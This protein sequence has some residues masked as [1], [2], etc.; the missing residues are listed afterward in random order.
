MGARLQALINQVLRA[1]GDGCDAAVPSGRVSRAD[2]NFPFP[3]ACISAV[4]GVGSISRPRHQRKRNTNEV[5][6]R[7]FSEAGPLRSTLVWFVC[8]LANM[9][10]GEITPEEGVLNSRGNK[11]PASHLEATSN[12]AGSCS[13]VSDITF[14]CSFFLFLVLPIS[15]NESVK[16]KWPSPKKIDDQGCFNE[17]C[18]RR[19][20]P[21]RRPATHAEREVDA[22]LCRRLIQPGRPLQ[23]PT[24]G[25]I[26]QGFWGMSWDGL[27][28][29]CPA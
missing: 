16:K 15:R 4:Q 8:F 29:T 22:R 28:S 21:A 5:A 10:G 3:H 9:V 13:M 27:N 11:Q 24:W 6:K 26:T 7:F 25:V 20:W 1:P 2:N 23:V 19:V 12:R 14:V 18:R 17:G